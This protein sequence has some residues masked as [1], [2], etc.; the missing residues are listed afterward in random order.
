MKTEDLVIEMSGKLFDYL[1]EG[2]A[3]FPEKDPMYDA[4]KEAQYLE[5]I[6]SQ[7][8]PR[9][10]ED[11]MRYLSKDFDPKNSWWGSEVE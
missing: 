8:M 4:E 10:E 11:R 9:L 1:L 3:K 5:R 2:N 6:K 7:L